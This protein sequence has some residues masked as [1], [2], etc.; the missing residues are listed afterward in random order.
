MHMR[1]FVE[2]NCVVT[3]QVT[4]LSAD[5]KEPGLL[6]MFP[7]IR[8]E[9]SYSFTIWPYLVRRLRERRPRRLFRIVRATYIRYKSTTASASLTPAE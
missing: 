5:K 9:D 4:V 3:A 7:G 6:R 8:V 1:Y 2:M